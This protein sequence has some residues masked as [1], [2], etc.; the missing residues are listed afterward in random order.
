MAY[1]PQKLIIREYPDPF[2][3]VVA[4]PV[5]VIN[6]EIRE[7][8]DDMLHTMYESEGVGLAGTQVG[9][10]KRIIVVDD[11]PQN[12]SKPALIMINPVITAYSGVK[13]GM[14]QCLSIPDLSVMVPRYEQIE[15]TYKDEVGLSHTVIAADFL[16]VIIQHEISHLNGETI[17]NYVDVK[18]FNEKM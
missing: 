11:D 14:E 1:T 13:N 17:R 5:P 2:L 7:L 8:A 6:E 16:S 12:T 4:K 10:D 15:V 9:E 18:E 3:K